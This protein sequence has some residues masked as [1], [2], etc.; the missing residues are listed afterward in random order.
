MRTRNSF[1]EENEEK[2]AKN[3]K[4][5]N[6]VKKMA[7]TKTASIKFLV[8]FVDCEKLWKINNAFFLYLQCCLT[9]VSP[10]MAQFKLTVLVSR[11]NERENSEMLT[12]VNIWQIRLKPLW[13]NNL[14]HWFH[15]TSHH[16]A[17]KAI[18]RALDTVKHTIWT[19]S[20]KWN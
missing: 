3:A 19:D 12:F 15:R 1:K 7:T 9:C 6:G 5:C 18:D 4:F 11:T 10:P 8:V 14:F 13:P 20:I 17:M 2:G 16:H